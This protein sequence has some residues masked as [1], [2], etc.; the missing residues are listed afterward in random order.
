MAIVIVGASI[1]AGQLQRTFPSFC[2]AVTEECTIEAGN[3][4]EPLRQFRLVLVIKKIR[5][6]NQLAGLLLKHFLNGRMSMPERIHADAAQE[7]EI[8]LALRIPQI[9]SAPTREEDFLPVIS[10]QKQF[11]FVPHYGSQAHAPMTSVPY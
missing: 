10:R 1:G 2:S 7:I 8:A 5:R 11:L 3:F 6:V 4:R 9:N